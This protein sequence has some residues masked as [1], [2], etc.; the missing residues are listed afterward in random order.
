[1]KPTKIFLHHVGFNHSFY[2]VNSYHRKKWNFKSELGWYAGYTYFIDNS[3]KL[4]QARKD[5]E[6]GAH[7]KGH[8]TGSIGI[9][10]RGNLDEKHPTKQQLTTLRKLLQD[11]QKCY[12]IPK[13]E[14]YAHRELSATLCPGKNL[15]PFIDAYKKYIPEKVIEAAP[16]VKAPSE[17][18]QAELKG[19]QKQIDNIRSAIINLINRIKEYVKR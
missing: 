4:F 16:D 10:L 15:M 11:K 18:T 14:I 19:F 13:E 5:D 9:C 8:N 17:P 2:T 3:G 6:E 12:G 7:T 1:M